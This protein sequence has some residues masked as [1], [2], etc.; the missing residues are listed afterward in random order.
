MGR[1]CHLKGNGSQEQATQ[2]QGT[3]LIQMTIFSEKY[4]TIT[5]VSFLVSAFLVKSARLLH[6]LV[7][8]F[9][10][11]QTTDITLYVLLFSTDFLNR[12]TGNPATQRS[13]VGVPALARNFFEHLRKRTRLK[14]PFFHFHRHFF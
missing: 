2:K 9:F 1:K 3:K 11:R 7:L 12:F 6:G 13:R 8:F 10:F 5:M 14:G 4:P